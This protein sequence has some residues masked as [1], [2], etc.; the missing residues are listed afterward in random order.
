MTFLYRD[1]TDLA[2]RYENKNVLYQLVGYF[3]S[4]LFCQNSCKNKTKQKQYHK[5]KT[6][7]IWLTFTVL[8]KILI[9]NLTFD[10]NI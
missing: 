6:R 10:S 4:C 3:F 8:S 1:V 7:H 2:K 9:N 5:Q